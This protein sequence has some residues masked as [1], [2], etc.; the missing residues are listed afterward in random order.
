LVGGFRVQKEGLVL[1]DKDVLL[2]QQNQCFEKIKETHS[3]EKLIEN[4]G[5]S[6]LLEDCWHFSARF[7][8][9]SRWFRRVAD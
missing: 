4:L 1:S 9:S 2:G 3:A 5:K 8:V 6:G 7:Y